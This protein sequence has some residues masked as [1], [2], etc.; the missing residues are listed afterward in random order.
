[1]LAVAACGSLRALVVVVLLLVGVFAH[2]AVALLVMPQV[3]GS[4]M[5]LQRA[6]L[7]AKLWG[8]AS[9]GA[10]V[11][12]SLDSL[13]ST[14]TQ[15]A[16]SGFF[17][18]ELPP[19]P[20]SWNHTITV[21]S[22]ST[23]LT[24]ADVAFGDVVLCLGS[25]NL[26]RLH[27]AS[28]PLSP[29][30][31]PTLI[32]V[33]LTSL[34]SSSMLRRQSNMELAVNW[35]FGGAETIADSVNHPS[36]R[37]F[38]VD[39]TSSSVPLND[40][41]NRWGSD[42]WRVASPKSLSCDPNCAFGY[43][44]AVCY[45]YALAIDS[46]MQGQV[47]LGL[48][49]ATW[50]G[51]WVEQWTRA[52]VVPRCGPVPHN[53]A[54][55]GQIWN[56]MVA[57]IVN[58]T[59]MLTL[60]YQGETNT[61]TFDDALH[62]GCMFKEMITDLRA[63]QRGPSSPFYFVL[64]SPGHNATNGSLPLIQGWASQ[65]QALS[66]PNT[67]IANTI[68]L[69]D[70]NPLL[71]ELHPRNKSLI[72]QRLARI[73]LNDLYG[74]PMVKLG[75]TLNP[76]TDVS[77]ELT[78]EGELRVTFQFPMAAYNS[79]LHVLG[80]AECSSCCD[81]VWSALF[82]VQLLNDNSTRTLWPTAVQLDVQRKIVQGVVAL[83]SAQAHALALASRVRV[84]FQ[85]ALSYPECALYNQAQLPALP[86]SVEL[87]VAVNLPPILPLDRG[88]ARMERKLE[89]VGLKDVLGQL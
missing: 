13:Q 15:A 75:P 72:G 22:D 88:G 26:P 2:H 19:H 6:P 33:S 40:T 61:D 86:Y 66:L 34:N 49:Q 36:I 17:Q 46:A 71:T 78:A 56:G 73:A 11:V 42:S 31:T 80:T 51:T 52:A 85:N 4:H 50:G 89:R 41:R 10:K 25:L 12:V 27:T 67:A 70:V 47:P 44:S 29:A 53:N 3:F 18:V 39:W 81:G 1:M 58:F 35:T 65:M 28:Q 87:S 82:G 14:S 57:P 59:V 76:Q 83:P 30:L 62:Y 32:T 45:H 43:F 63:H 23:T 7:Q 8:Q 68:D 37:L 60:W 38:T 64:L 21:V 77:A 9:A 20:L 69:G 79:L 48:M 54:S 24:F 74:Q 5:V 84:D 16:D 55:T